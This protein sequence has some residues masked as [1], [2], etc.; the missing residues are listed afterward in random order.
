MQT[1]IVDQTTGGTVSG[2]QI[3]LILKPEGTLKVTDSGVQGTT[4]SRWEP[5]FLTQGPGLSSDHWLAPGCQLGPVGPGK[6]TPLSHRPLRKHS[7]SFWLILPL[8]WFTASGK[9]VIR[10]DG[11]FCG[12]AGSL[13][14]LLTHPTALGKSHHLYLYVRTLASRTCSSL[15]ALAL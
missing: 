10:R 2:W 8:L 12:L 14:W 4:E 11:C 9:W 3:S 13:E 15:P 6:F 5:A 7:A 1:D